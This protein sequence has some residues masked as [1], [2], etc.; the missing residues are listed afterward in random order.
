MTPDEVAALLKTEIRFVRR[1]VAERRIPFT[2]VGKF[3]R[4]HPADVE[5]FIA[6]GRVEPPRV[7]WRA[8]VPV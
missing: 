6:A 2:K 3:V 1:L 7:R 8:G 5:A 4:F